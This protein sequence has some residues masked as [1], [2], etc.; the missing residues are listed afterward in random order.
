M[1]G[2]LPL[3]YIVYFALIDD[4]LRD[5]SDTPHFFGTFSLE[6]NLYAIFIDED[7]KIKDWMQIGISY[8]VDL[9]RE[10]YYFNLENSRDFIQYAA[11]TSNENFYS[12]SRDLDNLDDFLD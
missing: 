6:D 8:M 5:N 2:D 12:F 10:K 1:M 11:F 7:S 9:F 4:R 3:D